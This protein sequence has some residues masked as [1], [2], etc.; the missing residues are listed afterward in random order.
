MP[1]RI[2]RLAMRWLTPVLAISALGY[3][4]AAQAPELGM[5]GELAKGGWELRLRSDNSRQKICVRS[6]REFLQ[7]RHKQS[8]CERFVVEDG[9]NTVTVQYTCRGDGYGRTTVR[10]ENDRLVQVRSQGIQ[11]GAPFT[12]DAEAR[13]TGAC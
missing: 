1:Q 5:L 8:G 2:A 13:H 7:L 3:P 12:I 4:V 10:R 9:A 11:G 6:G